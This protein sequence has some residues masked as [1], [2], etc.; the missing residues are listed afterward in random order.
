[1]FNA[2][3]HVNFNAIDTNIDHPTPANGGSFGA[4]TSDHGPRIIQVAGKFIF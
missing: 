2:F 3:N 1:M 4:V